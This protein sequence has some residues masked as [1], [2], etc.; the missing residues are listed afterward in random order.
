MMYITEISDGRRC[1]RVGD[2]VTAK[3]L[4]ENFLT[5]VAFTPTNTAYDD[6]MLALCEGADGRTYHCSSRDVKAIA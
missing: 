6:Y 1:L 5:I 3:G 4:D 2:V